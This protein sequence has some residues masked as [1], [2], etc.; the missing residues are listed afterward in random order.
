MG[1]GS[2]DLPCLAAIGVDI[3]SAFGAA[4]CV[5]PIV[6]M[7]CARDSNPL[8]DDLVVGKSNCFSKFAM[9]VFGGSDQAI[10]ENTSGRRTLLASLRSTAL[11]LITR[12]HAFVR[13]PAF[14]L[15]WGVYGGTYTAAN[16][17]NTICDKVE[18]SSTARVSSKFL[19]V[20]FTNLSLNIS[21][22]AIFT[23]MFAA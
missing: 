9:S 5:A 10:I 23:K 3:A 19:G 12:P 17:I 14:L 11:Q 21:K 20:S 13:K 18:A 6:S 8:L 15:L 22:D 4:F 16:T 2:R 1:R 7:M